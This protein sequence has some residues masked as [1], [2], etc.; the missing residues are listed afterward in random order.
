MKRNT[1][2]TLKIINTIYMQNIIGQ[3]VA[4]NVS[5]TDNVVLNRGDNTYVSGINMLHTEVLTAP[6]IRNGEA[7]VLVAMVADWVSVK[8]LVKI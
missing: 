2:I 6:Q 5:T 8:E 7:C 3:K 1:L 4:L